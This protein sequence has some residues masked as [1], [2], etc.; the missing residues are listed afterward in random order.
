MFINLLE[1]QN[2]QI[3]SILW[4]FTL[5]WIKNLYI[6][7]NKFYISN[8]MMWFN[9]SDS[10][11]FYYILFI[12]YYIQKASVA[13]QTA[14]ITTDLGFDFWYNQN[15]FIFSR[16]F[17]P[18]EGNNNTEC[19]FEENFFNNISSSRINVK[20]T[21]GVLFPCN[22]VQPECA[23]QQIRKLTTLGHKQ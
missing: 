8:K 10:P 6:N 9:S 21:V 5:T 13:K 3:I 18:S 19:I 22:C 16:S 15:I 12:I 11:Y 2:P 20:H 17:F 14:S 23:P 1:L 7:Y 4:S